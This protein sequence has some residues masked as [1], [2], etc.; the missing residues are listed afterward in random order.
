MSI[1]RV[2]VVQ[3]GP[4]AFDQER[5]ME[6]VFARLREAAD[7]GAQL[8]VFPESFLFGYP[9]GLDFGARVGMR[10]P[11]GRIEFQRY[12]ENAVDVPGPIT[13]ALGE[14]AQRHN[15]HIVIGVT[16]RDAGTLYCTA[17]FFPRVAP[18]SANTAN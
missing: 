8:V 13:A 3:D 1:V 16:E 14:A 18:C 4:Q 15:L 10:L 9:K 7:L 6:K 2:A 17:L 11:E 12:Y 5:T